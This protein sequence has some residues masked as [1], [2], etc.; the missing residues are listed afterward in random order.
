[1]LRVKRVAS[2]SR[3]GGRIQGSRVWGGCAHHDSSQTGEFLVRAKRNETACAST[4]R[5]LWSVCF[6]DCANHRQTVGGSV[7]TTHYAPALAS[8]RGL[9]WRSTDY[10]TQNGRVRFAA[11][12]SNHGG[13]R[14]AEAEA[15]V[16]STR[17]WP[18]AQPLR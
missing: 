3:N 14:R 16:C 6:C 15:H 18:A 11:A 12:S 13:R 10:S 8:A 1:M 9:G 7:I 4:R 2:A 17:A 5:L